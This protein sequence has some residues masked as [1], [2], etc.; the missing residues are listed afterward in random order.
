MQ[1]TK[2]SREKVSA[3]EKL[4]TCWPP[5]VN[6]IWADLEKN[7]YEEDFFITGTVGYSNTPIE[8]HGDY[9]WRWNQSIA[10]ATFKIDNFITVK[11]SKFNSRRRV[12]GKGNLPSY[13][14]WIYEIYNVISTNSTPWVYFFWCEKGK[15]P[16]DIYNP[17]DITMND[18]QFL[19]SFMDES[20]RASVGWS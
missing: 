4:L 3:M 13:K 20:E 18:L 12:T 9:S 6:A 7:A 8:L 10:N 1:Q 5:E 11:M 15:E 14:I 16:T 2:W 19:K 17:A